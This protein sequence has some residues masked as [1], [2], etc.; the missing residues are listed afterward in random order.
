MH[1]SQQPLTTAAP[2]TDYLAPQVAIQIYLI[3]TLHTAMA[4][5]ASTVEHRSSTGDTGKKTS[6]PLLLY[7]NT[8]RAPSSGL[9]EE[10]RELA[11]SS[12]GV[13]DSFHRLILIIWRDGTALR[14]SGVRFE[15]LCE[16]ISHPKLNTG[17]H[18]ENKSMSDKR[19][20]TKIIV[21]AEGTKVGLKKYDL[22]QVNKTSTDVFI[23][24]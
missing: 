1:V 2:P 12:G 4:T 6:A 5:A 20:L 3:F 9:K 19:R 11:N 23:S 17:G 14:S 21:F 7:I 18:S 22:L 15:G 13:I 8:A 16:A 10:L 24:S